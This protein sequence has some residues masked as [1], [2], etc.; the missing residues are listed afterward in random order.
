MPSEYNRKMERSVGYDRAFRVLVEDLSE[1]FDC[2]HHEL[3]IAKHDVYGFDLKSLVFIQKYS[4]N[5]KQ[6]A[7]VVT[8]RNFLRYSLEFNASFN[9]FQH[10]FMYFIQVM[11]RNFLR[12][13]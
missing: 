7:E 6:K 2:F 13:S 5:K 8:E 3:S 4:S 11:E 10:L 12:Y 9:H 1:A